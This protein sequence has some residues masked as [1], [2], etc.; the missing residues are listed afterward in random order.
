MARQKG[1][2]S[3][4]PFLL[5]VLACGGSAPVAPPPPPVAAPADPAAALYAPPE[6]LTWRLLSIYPHDTGAF[7][8]GL[9]YA[10]GKLYE[11]TG[12]EGRSTLREVE[13]LTGRVLRRRELPR[14]IFAEGLALVGAD[15]LVQL[16]WQNGKVFFWD[17]KTFEPRGEL[18]IAGEGWGLTFDGSR[19]IQ[20]DGSSGLTFR[21][22]QT[23]AELGR[24]EVQLEGRPLAQLNELEWVNGALWANVWQRDQI[25]RIDPATGRVTGIADL[26][27]LLSSAE[28]G[29]TDVLN[30]IAYRADT[31]T[32][33]VTGK[34][35]PKV[36][37]LVF[38]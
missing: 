23:F 7:T 24:L 26:S 19:L 4:A 18:S 22:P 33:L 17:R 14:P 36:F 5:L 29:G 13:L 31:G 10:D 3:S 28:R 11:S 12:L 6:E 34:L 38:E 25:A 21:D 27:P 2:A 16:S 8:Q 32:F 15:R 20:S 35:W 9:L 1:A 30:G 37:E